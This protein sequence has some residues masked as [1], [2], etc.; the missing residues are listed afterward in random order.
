MH[1]RERK[2]REIRVCVIFTPAHAHTYTHSSSVGREV[3][4]KYTLTRAV[5]LHTKKEG[6]YQL[7]CLLGGWGARVG[8][9]GG[10]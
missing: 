3:R 4:G 2:K 9:W 8:G 5:Y 1:K 10:G 7:H 6:W